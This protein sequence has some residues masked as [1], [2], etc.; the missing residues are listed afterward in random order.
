MT[1]RRW[2]IVLIVVG[3]LGL[4]LLSLGWGMG[5]WGGWSRP[6]W[7]MDAHGMGWMH[8][9]GP[10]GSPPSPGAREIRVAGSEFAFSPSEVTVPAGLWVSLVLEN[11]GRQPHDLTLPELGV[12]LPAAPGA[13][14]ATALRVEEPGRYALFCS[15]PGHREA[16]M[17]GL[18]VVR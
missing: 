7:M 13:T 16:G 5:P 4:G 11:R 18:L 14:S 17:T 12:F 8:G 2:G 10:G 9:R 1:A 15:V 6:G 3:I